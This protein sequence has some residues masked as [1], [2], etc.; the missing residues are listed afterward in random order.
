[1]VKVL[2]CAVRKRSE[3]EARDRSVFSS[4]YQKRF[5][6]DFKKGF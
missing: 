4:Y 5:F 3:G 1:M 2:C 6:D